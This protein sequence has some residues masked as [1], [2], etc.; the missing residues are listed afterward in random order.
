MAMQYDVLSGHLD[1]SGFVIPNGRVR[2]K[3]ITFQGSGAGAGVVEIFDTNVAPVSATYGR[4]GTLVTVTKSSH[5]LVTGDRIGIAFTAAAG[6]SATDGN[7]TITKLTDNTFTI[8]DPN[9]GTVT[10][11]TACKFVD[12]TGHS[13]LTS[14]S[15]T[16][17]QTTPVAVLIPGEGLLAQYG[18]YANMTNT[19]YVTVFYG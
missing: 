17:S 16:T 11:G 8:T 13:W 1:T 4:S 15:T 6:A 2:V 19:T 10:P 12:G 3:Q 7:Y 5:G 18:V 14:F 9:S